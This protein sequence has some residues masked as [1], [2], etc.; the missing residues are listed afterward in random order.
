MPTLIAQA[1]LQ[2]LAAVRDRVASVFLGKPDAIRL[3]LIALLADGH[4]LLEDVPGVGKTLLGKALAR[5]LS[6]TFSRIQFTPDL[7]PGDLLGTNVFRQATGTFDFQPGP[8][9]AQVILADEI[10]RAT[11]RTQSALL[12]AM[13]E[14]QVTTDGVSRKLG[15]PFLVVAT[16]N[17]YEFEGTYPLPESQLDRFLLRVKIGYTE[18]D[19]E[20]AILVQHRDGEPV[21]SLSPV[22]GPAE[23]AGLQAATHAVRVEP[24]VAD[25][26]LD[27]I[28][29][30]RT[31]P[32]VR[33]GAS[34]RAALGLY[35]AA[36][37]A[38]VLANRDYV[39]PDDVKG[40]AEPVL[41]HRL[42]TKAW[43]QGGRDDAGP[44]VRDVVARTR[45]PV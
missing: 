36:Q 14:R 11:P 38:A 39:T 24:P 1:L 20:R 30:T 40:L 43:D 32:D 29:G 7:L 34:T 3:S 4:L 44:V 22:I 28:V 25:Y 17:P 6:C 10:N 45:V 13:S 21:D 19:A 27:L 23:V 37:A 41:A 12:E 42:M 9:F 31:H 33:L 8:V 35:R 18:R 16:Q 26:V 15:P 5:S 2:S